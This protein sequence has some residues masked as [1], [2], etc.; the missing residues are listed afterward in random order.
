[1]TN[2]IL[3]LIYLSLILLIM[4]NP[5]SLPAQSLNQQSGIFDG[6]SDI[7][8]VVIPGNVTYDSEKQ[9]YTIEGS[10]TNI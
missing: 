9:V 2:K 5:N 10:G 8:K 7:G 1:M 6:H 4:L 3:H